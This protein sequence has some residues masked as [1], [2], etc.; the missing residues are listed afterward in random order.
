VDWRN[1]DHAAVAVECPQQWRVL[2]WS[3]NP[4]R[5]VHEDCTAAA[6]RACLSKPGDLHKSGTAPIRPATLAAAIIG[7]NP[8]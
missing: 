4:R 6:W 5:P 3:A 8:R 7:A 2:V 1:A